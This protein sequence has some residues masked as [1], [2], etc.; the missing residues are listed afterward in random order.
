MPKSAARIFLTITGVTASRIQNKTTTDA[1]AEGIDGNISNIIEE[2]AAYWNDLNSK[3][4]FAWYKNPF[5]WTITF[6]A[7]IQK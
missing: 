4:G 6:K 2:Y 5:A 7:T 3:K 1:I